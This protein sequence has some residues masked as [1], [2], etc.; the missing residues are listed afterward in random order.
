MNQSEPKVYY[1]TIK[2]FSMFKNAHKFYKEGF[3]SVLNILDDTSLYQSSP[4]EV[5]LIFS[6]LFT[7]LLKIVKNIFFPC[8]RC[9]DWNGR[10]SSSGTEPWS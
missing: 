7:S 3:C 1:N 8:P 5:T 10:Q 6:F 9:R 4:R 2:I